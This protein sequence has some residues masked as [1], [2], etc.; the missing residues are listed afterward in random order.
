[1][2]KFIIFLLVVVFPHLLFCQWDVFP[3][4]NKAIPKLKFSGKAP[5]PWAI[6]G[7]INDWITILGTPT[8]KNDFPFNPPPH[9]GFNW[10]DDGLFENTFRDADTPDA[11]HDIRFLAFINDDYNVYFYFRRLQSSAATNTFFYFLDVNPDGFMNYGEPVIHGDFNSSFASKFSLAIY[12]PN[13]SAFFTAGKGN[14]MIYSNA[15]IDPYSIYQHVD[16]FPM[17]GYVVDI[18]NQFLI[19]SGLRP[20]EVFKAAVTENGLGVEMSIP[21]RF[22]KNWLTNQY[23]LK[24]NDIFF[25]KL[26]LQ[27]GTHHYDARKIE[28]I[29]GSCCGSVGKSGNV[30]FTKAVSVSTLVPGTK[31]RFFVNYQNTT[32]AAEEFSIER[33]VFTPQN[34]TNPTIV[35]DSILA[36]PDYNSDGQLQEN[37]KAAV[38]AYRLANGF[39]VQMTPGKEAEMTAL[40]YGNAHFIVD[41]TIPPNSFSSATMGF[42]PSILFAITQED[43]DEA[44]GKTINPIGFVSTGFPARPGAANTVGNNPTEN[45]VN[46]LKSAL[47]F[48]NPSRGS[49][50]VLLPKIYGTVDMTVSDFSGRTVQRFTEVRSQRM[51]VSNMKPGTYTVTILYRNSGLKESKKIV[52]IE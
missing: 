33:M 49:F 39:C 7:R 10:A 17:P 5:P 42:E 19:G 51:Q 3:N 30:G 6:D 41:V 12:L 29:A 25:Y 43:C 26:E 38:A 35:D 36:Y 31:Y 34:Y 1:M 24:A 46:E 21:W 4:C 48:P 44:G 47:V 14:E 2:R 9:A 16:H 28:D 20:N 37:E 22:L 23:R 11:T 40:P 32:N 13:R 15:V 45:S 52:V 18:P 27:N 50:T 8:G